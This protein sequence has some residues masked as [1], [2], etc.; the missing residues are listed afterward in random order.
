MDAFFET[1]LFWVLL[2]V[3]GACMGSFISLVSYR[4]PHDLPWVATRSKCPHCHTALSARDLIPL[5]SYL[6]SGRACRYCRTPMSVRYLL[7]ELTT[8]AAFVGVVWLEGATP[9]AALLCVLA[10]C[11]I[12][13]S[14]TD[15]EHYMI[16]DTVQLGIL[17]TGLAYGLVSGA[18]MDDRLLHAL[19]AAGIGA[20]MHYGYFWL[21]GVHGLG[22]G[23]VKLLGACAV[24]LPLNA[25]PMFLMLAGVI[26]IASALI[27]RALGK[28][29][30]FP[31]GPAIAYAMVFIVLDPS[32]AGWI[33]RLLRQA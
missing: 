29:A 9:S 25:L 31:F 1:T 32:M 26:G 17:L 33:E 6:L 27:W 22:F 13:L 12:T 4:I 18:P 15:L 7:I 5:A 14:V 19:I 11:V 21:K 16:P 24:W 3:V 28:G 8:A 30:H 2:A 20:A 23:D 10:V